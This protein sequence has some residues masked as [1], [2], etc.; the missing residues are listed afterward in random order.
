MLMLNYIIT[1][2]KFKTASTADVNA[3]LYNC[4]RQTLIPRR[5]CLTYTRCV[6]H[7]KHVSIPKEQVNER[8]IEPRKTTTRSLEITTTPGTG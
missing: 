5:H 1:D 4:R 7:S 2:S 6:F 8:E 3:Q